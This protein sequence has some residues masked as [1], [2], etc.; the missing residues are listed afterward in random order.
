VNIYTRLFGQNADM[1][2]EDDFRVLLAANA[3]GAL[4]TALI[5]PV[6][7]SLTEPFGVSTAQIGLI[8]TAVSAPPIF[9]I[10]L[11]GVLTDRIGRKPVLVAGLL[12]F[13]T[14]GVL[15]A[16][17][18]NFSIVLVLRAL[19]GV[20][21]AGIMPVIITILGD[22]YEGKSEA[23]AQGIRFGVSGLSQ[24][25]FPA[26][27]GVVVVFAWHYPFLIYGLAVPMAVM[28]GLFFEE[29]TSSVDTDSDNRSFE[30]QYVTRIGRIVSRPR[31]MAYLIARAIIVL[32]FIGFLTYNSLVVGRLQNGTPS[33]AGFL[34]A[35]FSI[36]YAITSMQTGR[37]AAL[38]ERTTVPL[39]GAN[40]L[41]GGGLAVFAFSTSFLTAGPPVIAMGVGV[42]IT[43]SLYRSIITGLAP[44]RFRGGLVSIAESGGRVVATLTPI[45]IGA[46]LT[47]A[48]P[49]LGTKSAL[50]WIIVIAGISAGVIGIACVLFVHVV[51]IKTK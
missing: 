21:F 26:I 20:G 2:S 18:T 39:L 34:V 31:V 14:G 49:V 17:T 19:Q 23:T 35:L 16:S 48:E 27:A 47:R 22:L 5:S 8:V 44:Q 3:M 12:F 37:I 24:A 13:G 30:G 25:I 9:L 28:I 15:I 50:R 45:I 33:Q 40:V 36:V 29:P 38:F 41:L 10:P 32:P 1:M 51:N 43:F 6:L 7:S 4:G 42:G 11:S 46:T